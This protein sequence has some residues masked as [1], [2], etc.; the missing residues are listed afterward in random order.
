MAEAGQALTPS[1]DT[2]P[3]QPQLAQAQG[4]PR[5]IPQFGQF[6]GNDKMLRQGGLILGLVAAIA[7]GVALFYWAQEPVYRPL[8]SNLEER[9][10]AQIL[11]ALEGNNIPHRVDSGNG[12]IEVPV[13]DVHRVRMRLAADGLPQG[14]GVGF[15]MLQQDQ[16]FGTSQFIENARFQRAL[17]TE[18]SRSITTMQA[19]ESAR[20]HLAVPRQSVFVSQRSEPRASVV[21]QLSQ[22]G[23]LGQGQVQAIINLVASSVPELSAE[24]VTVVDQRG[25]LLSRR[26][27]DRLS[28]S[29]RHLEYQQQLEE[30]YARRVE[31][32][33][34]PI[35]GNGRVRAEV[36][37]RLDF[38]EE[39]STSEIYDPDRS[40]VRSEQVLE[41]RRRGGSNEAIGIPG[42]LTN[43]P[44]GIG[45]MEED[46]AAEADQQAL[47]DL[48]NSATRNFE[49]S[50]T[51][52]HNR[53]PTG[54]IERVTVAVLVDQPLQ[55][56][57]AGEMVRVPMEQAEIDQL[58]LLVQDAV[59]FDA[60]RGDTIN[61]ISAAFQDVVIADD[62]HEVPIWEQPWAW[63]VGK[64]VLALLLGLVLI[65]AVIRPLVMGLVGTRRA[66]ED[67]DAGADDVAQLEN[68]DETRQLPSPE[69]KSDSTRD[70]LMFGDDGGSYEASLTA[71]RQVVS[72]EPALAA[73]VVKNWLGQD[74]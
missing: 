42:A 69:Q 27:E 41:E 72:Q 45:Q 4:G 19:V 15:E 49:V 13:G 23:N 57:E 33:L 21:L 10:A 31:N 48:T 64:S 39:E 70:L 25:R 29:A 28:G 24:N 36:S 44:P 56:N 1:P 6:L 43:Q 65:L 58:T 68:D 46:A 71:A 59:G 34:A 37:A 30:R 67:A 12:T 11:A 73:N 18:L 16:S 38:S 50:R 17:E 40:A 61:V 60:A 32:L 9:D 53:R 2:A 20:V 51:V 5:G 62:P 54:V 52:T 35:V 7:V 47:F 26:E 74:D 63:E 66:D 55:A 22:G 8:Y 14:S 3:A